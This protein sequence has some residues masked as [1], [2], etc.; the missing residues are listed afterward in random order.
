MVVIPKPG[1]LSYDTPKSFHPIV[2]LNALGK[3][4]EKMLSNRL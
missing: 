2:L 3:M 4:F 1:E